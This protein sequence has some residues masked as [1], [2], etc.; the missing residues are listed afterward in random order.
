MQIE[1]L[2]NEAAIDV[3]KYE[4]RMEKLREKIMIKKPQTFPEAMVITTKLIDLDKDR[5]EI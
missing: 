3:L 5:R 1:H 2:S 4:I